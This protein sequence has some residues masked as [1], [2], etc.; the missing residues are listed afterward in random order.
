MKWKTEPPEADREHSVLEFGKVHLSVAQAS[1]DTRWEH[2]L[3]NLG[4]H[5]TRSHAECLREWPREAVALARA[6]L[7]EFEATLEKM[8]P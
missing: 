6:A 7:D 3:L 5:R 1:N 4:D 8:T 2:L